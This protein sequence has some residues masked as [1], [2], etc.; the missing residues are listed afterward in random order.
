MK[1]HAA[2]R[3]KFGFCVKPRELFVVIYYVFY[4]LVK[5]SLV[6]FCIINFLFYC[7]RCLCHLIFWRF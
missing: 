7:K 2:L 1:L 3:E 4:M 6:K 5:E